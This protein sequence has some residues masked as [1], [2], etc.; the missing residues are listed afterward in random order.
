MRFEEFRK[1]IL[2]PVFTTMQAR[3][4]S[5]A[6]FGRLIT[7]LFRWAK[8]GKLIRLKQGVYQ[9]SDWSVDEFSVAGFLYQPSYISLETALNNLGIIPDI[10]VN[11]T[12]VS[13]TTTKIIKTSK[14]TFFYSKIQQPLYFGWQIVKDP[15]GFYYKIAFAEKALL[16]WIYL[17]KIKN[18]TNYRINFSNLNKQ[19]LKKFSQVYPN[20]VK[21]AIHEQLDR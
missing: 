9:F 14:G 16:D 19:R 18:L 21:E 7:Q 3:N 6:E 15:E 20:W 11:V 1:F 17:R 4:I 8:Q 2:T 13:P 5:T 10:S 12:S